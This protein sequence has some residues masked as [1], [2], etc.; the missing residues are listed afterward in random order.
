MKINWKDRD[1]RLLEELVRYRE[2]MAQVLLERVPRL[3]QSGASL[4][5]KSVQTVLRTLQEEEDPTD[6]G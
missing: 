1:T 5:I 2:G 4:M 6:D 3:S